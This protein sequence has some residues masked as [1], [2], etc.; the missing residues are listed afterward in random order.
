AEIG[1]T[2][3]VDEDQAEPRPPGEAGQALEPL[4]EGTGEHRLLAVDHV[5]EEL[6]DVLLVDSRRRGGPAQRGQHPDDDFLLLGG[7]RPGDEREDQGN[8]E[9]DK[10]ATGPHCASSECADTLEAT[11]EGE[12]MI[13]GLRKECQRAWP[14]G[15]SVPM[16]EFL[17]RLQPTRPAMLTE[18]LSPVER[19]A[20]TAHVAY[21]EGLVRAG[22]VVLFGRTQTTGATTFGIVVFRAGDPDEA[23]RVM[24][25]DPAVRA[26]VMRGELFPFRIAGAAAGL[27]IPT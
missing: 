15:R 9:G 13:R 20:I 10:D 1:L 8:G 27:T 16:S 14:R 24:T 17:Y 11:T 25:D 23:R 12:G 2:L 22:V 4:V 7:G 5:G 18:G 21:L 19:D 6:V 3:M 26:G